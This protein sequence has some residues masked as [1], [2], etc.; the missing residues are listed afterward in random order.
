MSLKTSNY[1]TARGVLGLAETLLWIGVGLGVLIAIMAAGAA[2]RGFGASGLIAAF[3]GIS[4]TIISFLGVVMVQIGKAGVDSADYT[5]QM[6][7]IARDQLEISKRAV[8]QDNALEPGYAAVQAAKD[9]LR[10]EPAQAA[11]PGAATFA[12]ARPHGSDAELLVLSADRVEPQTTT[13][14]PAP[15]SSLLEYGGR[16]ILEEDNRYHVD[17]KAFDNLESAYLYIDQTNP[18]SAGQ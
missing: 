7:G 16:D 4:I 3:P 17:G 12:A 6:L 14:K 15:N 8:K 1:E 13:P 10:V 11:A 5:Y 18:R 2:S 9:A